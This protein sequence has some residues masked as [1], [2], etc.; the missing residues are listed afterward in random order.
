MSNENEIREKTKELLKKDF[1][2]I[3]V[4]EFGLKH[5][6]P[7]I[8]FL[9]D[10]FVFVEI[11]S[12]KDSL[13]RIDKQKNEYEL[14]SDIT[15]I[16]VDKI[17]KDKCIKKFGLWSSNILYYENGEIYHLWEAKVD[18]ISRPIDKNISSHLMDL[19]WSNERRQLL[20]PIGGCANTLDLKALK[21]CYTP[22]ELNKFSREMIINRWKH[23]ITRDKRYHNNFK[24]GKIDS[25]IE[26]IEHKKMLLKELKVI[27]KQRSKNEL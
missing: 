6:R 15:V 4:D 25:K 26:H 11:K 3:I 9:G 13:T 12:D 18:N 22:Y 23:L 2:G 5:T 14:Y 16:V 20:S 19:L 17:H 8:V 27:N 10:Y 7:D 1:D 21:Y 24:G